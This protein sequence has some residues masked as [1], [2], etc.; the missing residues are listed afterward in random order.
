MSVIYGKRVRLRAVEREDVTRF[1]E[2]VNDPEVTRGLSLYLPMSMQD[3]ENWF[4]GLA[5]RDPNE[6]PLSIEVRKGKGWKLIGNC[7]VFGI[8]FANRSA[9]LGI[10]IGDK[11]EW[12]KG[13]GSEAM[14]LLLR[15]CFETLNLNRAFLRVYTDNIR[16]VRSYEKVGFV[17]EG[18][19]REAVY[20]LGKYEDVLIMSVLRPEW[21]SRKKEK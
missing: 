1:Y 12:D 20:K 11:S 2:W 4:D 7:G 14:T 5:K 21:A 17:L 16:A 19:L 15:H 18:R 13:Y 6:R 9:E 10:M 3:E 8:E